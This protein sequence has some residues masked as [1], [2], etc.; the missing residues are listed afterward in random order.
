M[1]VAALADPDVRRVAIVRL[2]VGLGDLLCSVPALRSLR[3]ARPDLDVTLI[4]W[5]KMAPVVD[6][7]RGYVDR[8][9]P[10]PGFPGIP[11]GGVDAAGWRPFLRAASGF[12][13]AVQAYGDN[14]AANRVTA[15]LGARLVGGFWPT[16][17]PGSPPPLHL[18]YPRH[19]HEVWRHLRLFGHLGVAADERPEVAALEFPVW[20]ADEAED[21]VRRERHGLVPGGYVV[22][23][24]GASS[25]S[26]RWPPD[27]YAEV[28]DALTERGLRVVLTGVPAERHIAGAVRARSRSPLLDLTGETSLGGYALL[29]RNA[30]L[31]VCNDT[32]TAHLAAAVGTPSV[33]VF[34]AGD[35]VRWAYQDAQHRI[36][37]VAVGCNPCPHLTCPIDFRCALRLPVS[38]VLAQVDAV[39]RSAHPARSPA[40]PPPPAPRPSA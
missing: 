1:A 23:H 34:L 27:R 9:L 15:A 29:L 13:L 28:A 21:A 8:L 2:R 26:R 11:D 20:A 37:R 30:A 39:L 3:A 32:G 17:A 6:R 10:F 16:S 14:L 22:I 12:D 5:R 18:R 38:A 25:P 24:P 19:V 35:P 36:A 31:V 7:M 4:T 40:R 33:T